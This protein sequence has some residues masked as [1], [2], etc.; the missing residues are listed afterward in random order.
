MEN[1]SLKNLEQLKELFMKYNE[2]SSVGI[3]YFCLNL[4]A[5]N[6]FIRTKLMTIFEIREQK[7]GISERK[8]ILKDLERLGSV[9]RYLLT[10]MKKSLDGRDYERQVDYLIKKIYQIRE[11]Y[12]IAIIEDINRHISEAVNDDS[13]MERKNAFIELLKTLNQIADIQLKYEKIRS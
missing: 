3:F 1:N 2:N 8:A 7:L 12:R 6:N 10:I 9:E 5:P 11:E 4:L 13:N